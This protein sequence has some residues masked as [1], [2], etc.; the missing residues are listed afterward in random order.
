METLKIKMGQIFDLE[1]E[2]NGIAK[3]NELG[4]QVVIVKGFLLETLPLYTKYW[5]L[6]LNKEVRRVKT[7]IDSLRDELIKK[8]GTEGKTSGNI[9]I[10]V[11]LPDTE[12]LDE[13]GNIISGTINPKYLEFQ[14]EYMEL[15]NGDLEIQ[16]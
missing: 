16:P 7:S 14:K 6:E 15:L 10:S 13:N 5:L 12:V 2:I 11:Y 4:E 3:T 8:Y 9:S 1:A